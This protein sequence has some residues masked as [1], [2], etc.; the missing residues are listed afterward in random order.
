MSEKT[1]TK[2]KVIGSLLTVLSMVT[3]IVSAKTMDN[4]KGFGNGN[5]LHI[6][7]FFVVLLGIGVISAFLATLA[8]MRDFTDKKLTPLT[9]VLAIGFIAF[10]LFIQNI[11]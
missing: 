5:P 4:F 1:W 8:F 2:F 3:L 10:I 9:F 7:I 11:R 6:D